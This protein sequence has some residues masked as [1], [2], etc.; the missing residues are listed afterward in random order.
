MKIVRSRVKRLVR[1]HV[2][3]VGILTLSCGCGLCRNEEQFRVAS[4]DATLEAVIFQRDCGATTGF[5]TQ[6]SI[7]NKGSRL[8]DDGGNL[9]V[10]DTDH[11]K[12]PAAS[13]GGPEVEVVWE[14]TR[15]VR[16][17]THRDARVFHQESVISVSTGLFSKEEVAAKYALKGQ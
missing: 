10:A 9:F 14:S 15:T 5:S 2:L 7:I 11:G 4:P 13:W 1:I 8:T 16:V 6:I 17:L 12:A 3:L